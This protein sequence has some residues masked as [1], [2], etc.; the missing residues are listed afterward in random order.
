[1]GLNVLAYDWLS[2]A[3]LLM[4]NNTCG[5]S[6]N[7]GE[8]LFIPKK[9]IIFIFGLDGGGLDMYIMGEQEKTVSCVACQNSDG[10]RDNILEWQDSNPG[11]VIYE[12]W[13]I[14]HLAI[15]TCISNSM[16]LSGNNRRNGTNQVW[17]YIRPGS[18]WK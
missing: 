16:I 1:M 17:G 12:P 15:N 11:L 13:I 5:H 3:A 2:Y 10:A 4:G 8:L 6:H 18:G 9:K 7:A 14:A